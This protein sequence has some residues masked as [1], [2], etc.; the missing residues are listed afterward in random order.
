MLVLVFT[1]ALFGAG[2]WG[3]A[4]LKQE[5]KPEWLL[6]PDAEVSKW[7][8]AYKKFYP[9]NGEGGNVYMKFVNYPENFQNIDNLVNTLED[10]NDI[11]RTVSSWHTKFRVSASKNVEGK[12]TPK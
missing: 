11:I 12:N 5:F 1:A 9:S 7:Y 10:Q 4:E 8:Q 3:V 6:D 2:L